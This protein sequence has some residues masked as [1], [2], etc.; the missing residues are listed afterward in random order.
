[1]LFPAGAGLRATPLSV[2]LD[3]NRDLR[4]KKGEPNMMKGVLIR[5]SQYRS[6]A[7][8]AERGVLDCVMENPEA[9]AQCSI[10]KLAELSYTSPSTVV[11]ICRKLGFEGYREMQKSLLCEL[12]VR[13]GNTTSKNGQLEHTDQLSDIIDKVTYRNVAS[14]ENSRMLVEPESVKKSVDLICRCDTVLLFG[15]GASFLVAHDAYLKFLRVGK[16][17]ALSEDIHSQYLHARN[18]KPEDL[19][20]IISYTGYTD[21]ILRCARDLRQQGTPIVAITRFEPSPLS[22]MADCSLYVAAAEETFRGGAMSSRI[23]QLNMVD[24]LYTA[25]YNR[26]YDQSIRSF[27][28]TQISKQNL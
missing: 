7:S 19:A 5:M 6:Q 15:L 16:R 11:R 26:S 28:R 27:Q 23:A 1:M 22:Q 24:I 14:L 4:D 9:A 25:Y 13:G 18:A 12:A 20:I 2:I 3:E 8:G 17:C 21:E 10:H